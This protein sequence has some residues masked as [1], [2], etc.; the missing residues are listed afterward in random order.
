[1]KKKVVLITHSL[2]WRKGAGFWSRTRELLRFLGRHTDLSVFFLG[3]CSAQEKALINQNYSFLTFINLNQ[4]KKIR[5]IELVDM[6]KK[7]IRQN[8]TA[9]VYIIDKTENS[10][11]LWALSESGRKFVDTHDLIS[12]RTRS[13][14]QHNAFSG[15]EISEEKEKALL[16]FY[17]SV[18]CIQ[19]D[20]CKLVSEWIGQDKAIL[21]PHPVHSIQQPIR[22]NVRKIGF[23]AS[24]WY[25]N[26][27]GL[28]W[29]L[30]EVWRDIYRDGL[31]LDVYGSI[32]EAFDNFEAPGVVFHGF[33]DDLA[34][35]Y[36]QIDIIINPVRWGAGLKI[37]T[38]E[39]MAQGL[40][41]VISA[42]GGRGLEPLAGKAF[43]VAK[44]ES[45]FKDGLIN[46]INNYDLRKSLGTE[47]YNFAKQNLSPD[48]CFKELLRAINK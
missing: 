6:Y 26:A 1:L 3:A 22:E 16:Q 37:K 38:V 8:G 14:R 21:A 10:Y 41:L 34:K 40:P 35:A 32:C 43:M 31:S 48:K 39:A 9:D 7:Y 5:T 42:E 30:E 44:D 12:Q 33:V 17:D 25:A 4:K 45:G 2:F 15:M 20:D 47:G 13:A 46:L 11:M 27:D 28:Q 23:I 24:R 36:S 18:I 29:F 19:E